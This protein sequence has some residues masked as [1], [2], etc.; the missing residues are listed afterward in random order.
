MR[1]ESQIKGITHYRPAIVE[2]VLLP[3]P[4]KLSIIVPTSNTFQSPYYGSSSRRL[5]LYTWILSIL[6]KKYC[7]GNSVCGL[8]NRHQ[9]EQSEYVFFSKS[10]DGEGPEE[11]DK[12]AR[13]DCFLSAHSRI[14]HDPRC[15]GIAQYF[16]GWDSDHVNILKV[17]VG[18]GSYEHSLEYGGE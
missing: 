13:I 11:G 18:L 5:Q 17:V 10:D 2:Q 4:V 14:V 7:E 3:S 6:I 8:Y 1:L 16:E 9:H 12:E 15:Q